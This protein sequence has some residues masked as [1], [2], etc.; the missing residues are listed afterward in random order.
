MIQLFMFMTN[1]VLNQGEKQ[2]AVVA[3]AMPGQGS[4]LGCRL[5]GEILDRRNN[6]SNNTG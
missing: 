6:E 3:E 2:A 5:F 4:F 1:Y